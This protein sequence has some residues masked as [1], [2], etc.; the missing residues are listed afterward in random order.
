MVSQLDSFPAFILSISASD[1]S[2]GRPKTVAL[3]MVCVS[4]LKIASKTCVLSDLLSARSACDVAGADL[5]TLE[6]TRVSA[7]TGRT[8]GIRAGSTETRDG[9]SSF[10]SNFNL[11]ITT[12]RHLGARVMFSLSLISQVLHWVVSLVRGGLAG[13]CSSLCRAFRGL[14]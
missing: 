6:P 12:C 13:N 3:G 5:P 11:P 14:G 8:M 4:L 7:R 2:S 10:P 9:G 1:T